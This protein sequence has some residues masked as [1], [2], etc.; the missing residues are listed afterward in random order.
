MADQ[1]G[2]F[3][4]S[5]IRQVNSEQVLIDSWSFG[6]GTAVILQI[7]HRESHDVDI[8]LPDPQ[9]LAFL[10]PNCTISNLKSGRPITAATARAS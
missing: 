3:A 4:S 10:D 5:L 9:L 7:N 2:R 6:G 1:N 8:F